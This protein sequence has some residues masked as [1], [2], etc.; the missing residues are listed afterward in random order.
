MP[1]GRFITFEGGEGVGK[2]T[3]THRLATRVRAAGFDVRLTREP[4]GTPRAEALREALLKGLAK[5]HGA[6]AETLLFAAARIDHVDALIAPAL[7]QGAWVVCDRF[8]DSTRAYQGALGQVDAALITA[9]E[10][11]SI[12]AVR[13]DLTLVLDIPAEIGVARAA[14]RRGSGVRDR[15]EAETLAYHRALRTAFLA[16]AAAEPERCVVIDARDDANAVEARIW[17]AV[18]TRLGLA[19]AP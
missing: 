3:Q 7:A 5:D 16:I 6:T 14:A 12:G 9:L 2:S 17:A 10:R 11:V 4:G 18:E 15:F 1:R 8:I 13:P 19:A